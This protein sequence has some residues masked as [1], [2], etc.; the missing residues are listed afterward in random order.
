MAVA[1]NT[2]K[3]LIEVSIPLEVINRESG[4]EKLIRHGHPSTLHLWWSRKPLATCRAI[5]FAQLVD[6]PGSCQEEFPSREEQ[7]AE[8]DRLHNLIERMVPWAASGNEI[9]LNEAR[10]EIA[11]SI[12]RGRGERLP[13]IGR[14]RPQ[15]IIDYLQSNAPPVYDPFSGGGSIPLEAQ[16]LGLKAIGSD[17]NPVAVLIGKAM[18]E[19]PPKFAGRKPVNPDVN[20]LHQ[21]KGAQGLADDVRYYGRWLR[22]QAQKKIGYLYPKVKLKDG[23][24]ATVIA[25][26]W[27]RTVPSPDPRAKGTPVPLA[28]T[29][30]LSSRAG[31]EV[32]VKPVIDRAKMEWRFEIDDNPNV[33]ALKA[34]KNG[35]KAA[36][37]ANFT[38][39]LTGATIDD[40][41]VKAEAMA[42]R[43]GVALMAIV[44]D[45]GRRRVYLAP[46]QEHVR[47]AAIEAPDVPEVDQPLPND[48]RAI[49]CTLYGLDRFTKLFT[50]RQLVALTTF[51]DLLMDARDKALADAKKHWSGDHADDIVGLANG[52]RGPKAYADAVTTYLAFVI[53][54]LSTRS[55]TQTAWYVDRESTMAAFSRQGIPMNWGFA[56][57]NTLLE[58]SGSFG[59]ALEWTA[60][61][62]DN[63]AV[64]G[65]FGAVSLLDAAQNNY[66]VQ[67]VV[68]STDPPYYD[69]IGYAD[70]SDFF[71][72]WLRRALT[73]LWPELFRRI[74]TPK[75][76]EL[77][78]NPYRQ[79]GK[80]EAENFFMKGMGEALTALRIAATDDPLV[81]Y[82]AFK[83][84]E[85]APDGITSAGWASF[86]QAVIHSG[87][88]VDGTWPMR[89]EQASGLRAMNSNSLASSVVLVCRRRDNS[90]PNITRADFLRSLRREMPEALAEIRRAGVGPTD[91]QQAA[92]GPGIGIF[93]RHTSVLNTDGTPMLVKDA[94]KLV[95]QVREEITS[96]G[97]GDYDSETR[98]ALDWFAAKG[99]DKGKSGDAIVMTNAVNVSLD[100]VKNAG[101][102]EAKGGVAR[103]LKREEL[104]DEWGPAKGATVW[105][106][107]QHLIK[108]LTAEDGGIEAAAMLYNRLG[109]LAEPAHALARRLYDICEQKKWASEGQVYNQLH[110]EWDVIEKRAG[111]LAETGADLFSR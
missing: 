8:R 24:E 4:R 107:C 76:E 48:P 12:A 64:G 42:G 84:S 100:G 98:F 103:L 10:Y 29:F 110:Q 37:G 35:T 96:S 109:A 38:C 77:V 21:W 80:P 16:R 26:L 41:H 90:A 67:S 111:K 61:I 94:L 74:V 106:A 82:Y 20:E 83:Q 22:E 1:A 68:I 104:S 58:G 45:G 40:T 91:I 70:L 75:K 52:G 78:A 93:T 92:I 36:R 43:M 72:V 15:Q 25:W 2:R 31:A 53:S 60:E 81:I 33:E 102:F 87:L 23:K 97:D 73:Q 27:A 49:W 88:I 55:C 57:M 79:G 47:A 32:I 28:S 65:H 89:T 95:N 18:V 56:E 7:N 101:F 69:N 9:I 50:P 11:R 39:L 66:P 62:I 17:V 34:A 46:T 85:I 44:A 19:I 51:S 105:E 71:Y 14:M 13:P 3:K 63:L 86:L 6:D 99:F 5:L 59:N 54:K 30:L 108:R